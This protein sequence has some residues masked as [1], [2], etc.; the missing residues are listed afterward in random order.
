M[1]FAYGGEEE[2]HRIEE[3]D[4]RRF[5]ESHQH[6]LSINDEE[7]ECSGERHTEVD[8]SNMQRKCHDVHCVDSNSNL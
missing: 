8:L 6:V 3:S 4:D 2:N 5:T 7:G 1:V